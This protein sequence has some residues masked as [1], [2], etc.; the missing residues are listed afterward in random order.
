MTD[1]GIKYMNENIVTATGGFCERPDDRNIG[2]SS[3]SITNRVKTKM[4]S[5]GALLN[6]SATMKASPAAKFLAA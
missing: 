6:Q 3:K 2:R 4:K 1:D 5:I